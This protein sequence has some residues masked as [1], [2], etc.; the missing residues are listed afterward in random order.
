MTHENRWTLTP[1][2]NDDGFFDISDPVYSLGWLFS[3]GAPPPP[4]PFLG[5]GTDPTPD[6]LG[7]LAYAACP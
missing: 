7:C 2:S 3:P 6:S 5:C 1:D 4:A